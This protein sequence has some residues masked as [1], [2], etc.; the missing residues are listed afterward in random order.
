MIATRLFEYCLAVG[1]AFILVYTAYRFVKGISDT[2]F[3]D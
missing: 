1:A 3:D 2:L